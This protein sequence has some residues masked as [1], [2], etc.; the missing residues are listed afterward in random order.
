MQK[1]RSANKKKLSAC[2]RFDIT[3]LSSPA[4]FLEVGARFSLKVDTKVSFRGKRLWKF[5]LFGYF[6]KSKTECDHEDWTVSEKFGIITPRLDTFFLEL[7]ARFSLNVVTNA[8][9]GIKSKNVAFLGYFS[10]AKTE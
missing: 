10:E 2:N 9:L 6:S 3:I 7:G 4:Y 8:F 5:Q 1:Q